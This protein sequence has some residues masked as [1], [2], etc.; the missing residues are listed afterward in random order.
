MGTLA[1]SL[2]VTQILDAQDPRYFRSGKKGVIPR[3][4]YAA[5]RV[6]V[7]RNDQ[8]DSTFHTAE[9]LGTLFTS[10]LQNTYYPHSD[11]GFTNTMTRFVGALGSD[12]NSNILRE[13]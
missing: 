12:A 8:G 3:S 10:S 5:T 4:W 9:F 1:A 2:L 11:R 13:F 6:F 7:T